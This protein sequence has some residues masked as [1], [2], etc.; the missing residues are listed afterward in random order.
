MRSVRGIEMYEYSSLSYF[1]Q[2]K[3]SEAGDELLLTPLHPNMY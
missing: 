3:G 2:Y 1:L